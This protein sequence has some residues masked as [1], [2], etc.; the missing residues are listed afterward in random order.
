LPV[1]RRDKLIKPEKVDGLW[2]QKFLITEK[3]FAPNKQSENLNPNIYLVVNNDDKKMDNPT[4]FTLIVPF[5]VISLEYLPV[6]KQSTV[7]IKAT[8]RHL[9]P[10]SIVDAQFDLGEDDL[11]FKEAKTE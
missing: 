9:K 2:Q 1:S 5:N 8:N 3:Y 11:L 4:C 6:K 10:E 7:L